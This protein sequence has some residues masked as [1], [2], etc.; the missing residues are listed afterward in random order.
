MSV[1]VRPLYKPLKPSCR[2]MP[3]K[4]PGQDRCSASTAKIVIIKHSTEQ[5]TAC[6]FK[7]CCCCLKHC[8]DEE[9]TTASSLILSSRGTGLQP[10][11]IE[12]AFVTDDDLS[13]LG[14]RKR[15]VYL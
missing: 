5:H 9:M 1:G 12:G 14:W 8:Y 7:H 3:A 4:P 6:G 15:N 11:A 2:T 13:R 10:G